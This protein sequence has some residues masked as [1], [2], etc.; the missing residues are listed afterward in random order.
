MKIMILGC[1]GMLGVA[2]Q[3]KL[4]NDYDVIGIDKA[5]RKETKIKFYQLNLLEFEKLQ[6]ILLEER[7]DVIINVAAIV[8]LNLCEEDKKLAENL[9]C[10]LSKKIVETSLK[11]NSKYI[12]ISTD[13][14]FDGKLGNYKEDDISN[15]LNNYALTKLKGEKATS[16]YNNSIIIRTNIY[17]Y[18]KNQNSLLKWGY[19]SLNNDEEIKGYTNVIFNPVS[20]NQLAEAINILIKKDFK[21][22]LNIGS[23][24]VISKYEFL[25]IIS[26]Y[27]KRGIIKRSRIK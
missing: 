13:S 8:N 2:L 18:S 27:L 12:Y 22:I 4:L 21:G 7:P 3:N 23:D 11:I 16:N 19:N 14:I 20:V 5:I 6:N 17:G 26:E 1:N 10:N 9:H 25:H 15:P 24:K